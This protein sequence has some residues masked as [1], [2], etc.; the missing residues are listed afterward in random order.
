MNMVVCLFQLGIFILIIKPM[1]ST[2][3]GTV[4]TERP[5]RGQFENVTDWSQNDIQIA[6]KNMYFETMSSNIQ[7]FI[8]KH[9]VKETFVESLS[10]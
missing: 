3:D 5:S 7:I 9:F 1:F 6:H 8:L 2:I 10:L 4:R